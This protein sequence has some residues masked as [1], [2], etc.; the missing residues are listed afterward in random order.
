MLLSAANHDASAVCSSCGAIIPR[1]RLE[2]HETM[3]CPS[4]IS[5]SEGEDSDPRNL[6]VQEEME[7]R[8]MEIDE[9]E[10]T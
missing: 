4:L 3:W 7:V 2:V 9:G 10:C 1:A 6:V 5:S 8:S